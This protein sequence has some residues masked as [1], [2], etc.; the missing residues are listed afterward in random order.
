MT[1]A[2]CGADNAVRLF[3]VR[4]AGGSGMLSR[5][6]PTQQ[7]GGGPSPLGKQ[8]KEDSTGGVGAFFGFA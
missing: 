3:S 8:T 6:T 2:S 7:H 1:L 4:R 5:G